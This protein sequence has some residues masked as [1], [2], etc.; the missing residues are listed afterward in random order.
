MYVNKEFWCLR[1]KHSSRIA[2][3]EAAV[4]IPACKQPYWI[5]LVGWLVAYSRISKT[6]SLKK[7]YNCYF[8]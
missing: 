5:F 7:H 4:W 1:L 3:S 8:V 2:I 6:S